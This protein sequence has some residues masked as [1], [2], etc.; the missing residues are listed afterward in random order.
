[1]VQRSCANRRET[2]QRTREGFVG[3]G[4]ST[5]IAFAV[6]ALLG[7][8]GHAQLLHPANGA[9]PSFEVATVRPSRGGEVFS[10]RFQPARFLAENV[11]LD[12][13]I[14][15][16]YDVRSD[17]QVVN[18]SGWAAPEH[19]DIDAKISDAEVETIKKLPADQGFAQYRL[20]VQALLAERFRMKVRTE[21]RELPVYALIVAKNGPKLVPS[22]IVPDPQKLQLPQLHF[23]AAGALKAANVSMEYFSGWL[24]GR[25]DTGDRVVIDATGLKGGYDFALHW[26]PVEDGSI[27][28]G[29]NGSQGAGSAP[30]SDADKPLLL[31]AIQE[32][33]GLKLEPR[34]APVEVLVIEHVEQPSAN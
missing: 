15:F 9:A 19:Y 34:K 23:T 16:A 21:T 1:M 3:S 5:K 26:S 8:A 25:Q 32:Q 17:S 29:A 14:R 18:M 4:V 7:A 27:A 12:R 20:M 6:V 22:A 31:T 30:A 33:L 11:P 28:G 24:S 10:L 13:L 2:G